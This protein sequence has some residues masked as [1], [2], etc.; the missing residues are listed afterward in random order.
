M[1]RRE[2]V[3]ALGMALTLPWIARAQQAGAVRRI[4]E[5]GET[6]LSAERAA[7]LAERLYQQFQGKRAS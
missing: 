1:R 3:A 4:A 6:E 5:V 7:P 2:L